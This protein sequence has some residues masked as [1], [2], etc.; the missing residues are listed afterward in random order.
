MNASI[1]GIKVQ[2][3]I[4]F[5]DWCPT[6]FKVC[7]PG[8]RLFLLQLLFVKTIVVFSNCLLKLMK[9][10]CLHWFQHLRFFEEV[11]VKSI[12][13]AGCNYLCSNFCLFRL[14]FAETIV[15]G[16]IWRSKILRRSCCKKHLK[17]RL[18]STT[19]LPLWSLEGTSLKSR[20]HWGIWAER[21][22][23]DIHSWHTNYQGGLL[24]LQHHCHHGGLGKVY[25][26]FPCDWHPS[27]SSLGGGSKVYGCDWHPSSDSTTSSTWCMPREPS[28]TGELLTKSMRCQSMNC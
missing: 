5:V 25:C 2:K 28:S 15:Y 11:V 7:H 27:F 4:Q 9:L 26:D 6:G 3:N 13:N 22:F 16:L 17:C 12:L 23:S 24:S 14:L 10:L 1:A 21:G 8:K 20:G 19:S 18:G